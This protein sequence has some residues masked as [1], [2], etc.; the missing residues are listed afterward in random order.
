MEYQADYPNWIAATG[1]TPIVDAE[2]TECT[3]DNEGSLRR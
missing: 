2:R 3:L 1:T